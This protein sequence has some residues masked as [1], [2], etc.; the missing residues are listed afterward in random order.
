[1]IVFEIFVDIILPIF[2]IIGCGVL[3][4]RKFKVDLP[5]M[6]KLNFYVFVP[7]LVFIKIMDNNIEAGDLRDIIVYAM[8]LMVA[9]YLLSWIISL[10]TK[11]KSPVLTM[12]SMFYNTGN[13]GI[14]L[15]MLAFGEKMVPV[16][17][18]ILMV[19]NFVSFSF[20]IWLLEK[21]KH[22]MKAFLGVFKV[23]VIYAIIFGFLIKGFNIE[24]YPQIQ[25]PLEYI[26]GG[27]I[28]IALLTLGVQLSRVKLSKNLPRLS[29]IV[30][31][32]LLISP[33]LAWG[34]VVLMG[35][36]GALAGM[37]IITAGLPVAVNVYILSAEYENDEELASQAV[38]WTTLLS[39][40][41]IAV[42]I[43]LFRVTNG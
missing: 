20:G 32:R 34:I 22:G 37:L 26:A 41:S 23:P 19:Q 31:T 28:P 35:F 40:V 30:V 29:Q 4:D 39:V 27:L 2:F 21:D 25:Q 42:L 11:D 18:V 14:P 8:I 43:A 3:L 17:A 38:F 33:M 1:M 5:T 13:Y 7:A 24:L 6:S 16:I 12:G 10:F 9:L 36:E 15:T